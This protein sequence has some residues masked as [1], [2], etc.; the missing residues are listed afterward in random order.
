M[1]RNSSAEG[2]R[3]MSEEAS[4]L[5]FDRAVYAHADAAAPCSECKKPL[6][7]EYWTWQSQLLCEPCRTGVE[8]T[9]QE[10]QSGSSFGKAALWGGLTALG[11][12]VAYAIFVAVSSIQLALATI[13]IAFV[14]AKVV[15]KASR[16]IAG[17]RYQILAVALTY[18]ASAMGY[19]PAIFQ[20]LTSAEDESAQSAQADAK[21]GAVAAPSASDAQQ[22]KASAGELAFGVLFLF[23]LTLAAPFLAFSEAPMG[24]FIVLFGL[25]E[26]WRLSRGVPQEIA[27]PFRVAGPAPEA[28][29]T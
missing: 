13:G 10:A 15:R 12:G 11:C 1:V 7:N 20:G 3:H 24:F 2:H 19:A 27:G 5:S 23:G 25:W 28:T 16:G 22:E 14:V 17:R 26:A 21:D 6:E 4:E 18:G 29:T 9:F 8:R